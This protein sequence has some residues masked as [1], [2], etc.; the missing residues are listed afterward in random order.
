LLTASSALAQQSLPP[1]PKQF[2]PFTMDEQTFMRLTQYLSNKPWIE[3]NDL[4]N[5]LVAQERRAQMQDVP[6]PTAAPK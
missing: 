2:A 1:P 3:S 6:P 5:S 4:I